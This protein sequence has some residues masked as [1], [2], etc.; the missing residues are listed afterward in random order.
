MIPILSLLRRWNAYERFD[1][2]GLSH[3]IYA[4]YELREVNHSIRPVTISVGRT[5][6]RGFIGWLIAKPVSRSEV[7]L[8]NYMRLLDMAN[9]LGVGR[10]TSIGLGTVRVVPIR[11]GNA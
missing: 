8:R 7:R 9:Y 6:T 11:L 10:S 3:A 2:V 4:P 5:R 1:K